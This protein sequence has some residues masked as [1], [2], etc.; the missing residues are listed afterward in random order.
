LKAIKHKNK[1]GGL[2]MQTSVI[3]YPRIGSLRKLKFALEKYFR[4]VRLRRRSMSILIRRLK[5]A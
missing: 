4:R 3:G 5:S 1:A 2:T